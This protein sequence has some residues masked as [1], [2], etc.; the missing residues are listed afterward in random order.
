[1]GHDGYPS[2]GEAARF[3][4]AYT[5]QPHVGVEDG[6]YLRSLE[7]WRQDAMPNGA[8]KLDLRITPVNHRPETPTLLHP[9]G[10]SFYYLTHTSPYLQRYFFDK[11]G[12]GQVLSTLTVVADLPW[13]IVI[14]PW[15]VWTNSPAIWVF[16]IDPTGAQG[17]RVLRFKDDLTSRANGDTF[18][19]D[20]YRGQM[21]TSA[22]VIVCLQ[23][24]GVYRLQTL[25]R[26]QFGAE[27]VTSTNLSDLGLGTVLD[28]RLYLFDGRDLWVGVVVS[29]FFSYLCRYYASVGGLVLVSTHYLPD[30][31]GSG[32]PWDMAYDGRHLWATKGGGGLYRI[33]P[34]TGEAELWGIGSGTPTYLTWVYF[35]GRHVVTRRGD[36]N[37]LLDPTVTNGSPVSD[38]PDEKDLGELAIRY[39]GSGNLTSKWGTS[40]AWYVEGETGLP[41]V[42]Q[43][44][45]RRNP[46]GNVSTGGGNVTPGLQAKAGVYEYD[47]ADQSGAVYW[48]LPRS[49]LQAVVVVGTLTGT[50][51]I[52]LREFDLIKGLMVLNR[53]SG[54]GTLQV[55]GE[56]IPNG[57][58]AIVADS[59]APYLRVF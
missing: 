4:T 48:D 46:V 59:G 38:T 29:G 22:E 24:S 26:G 8:A 19:M 51:N 43:T 3:D 17:G 16:V 41:R 57:Q 25:L 30:F 6:S 54:G 45:Q 15:N 23:R 35:N 36:N 53:T 20:G 7:R 58:T 55:E 11:E 12:A 13:S 14:E 21:L 44:L 37:A 28:A 18:A 52:Q 56:T 40:V 50:L 10:D 33:D 47:A 31:Y 27:T 34:E 39:Y 49:N 42:A 9:T 1:M 2:S 5:S 32:L